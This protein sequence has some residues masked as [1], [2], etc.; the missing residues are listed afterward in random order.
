AARRAEVAVIAPKGFLAAATN[1]LVIA[2]PAMQRRRAYQF[3]I[4]LPRDARG[5]VSSGIGMGPAV[6]TASL[7]PPTREID[8]TGE[9][10]VIDGVR[11]VFQLTPGTEAVAEMNIDFPDWR[12]VD[13]A[14]NANSTQHN[15][16]T[17]RGAVV[18]DAKAWADHLTES[19]DLFGDSDVLITSHGWPRFGKAEINEY[20]EKHRD[21]YAFLHDQTVRLMNQGLT[22]DEIAE[23]LELPAALQK[24]W[25]DRPYYGSLS[26]NSR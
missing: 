9:T 19:I 2:E 10:L 22:G 4:F 26:F 11:M 23:R 14:E 20:L 17:P 12:I 5:Y 6:G 24:E 16:L 21:A 3:G 15:I 8:R 13:L 18:R 7:I 25:Y 1:E